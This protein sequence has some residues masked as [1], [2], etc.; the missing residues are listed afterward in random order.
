MT[1]LYV[2]DKKVTMLSKNGAEFYPG[3]INYI[4]K[5]FSHLASDASLKYIHG[6]HFSFSRISIYFSTTDN[7]YELDNAVVCA[8]LNYNGKIYV[9]FLYNGDNNRDKGFPIYE[10]CQESSS[11]G[12]SSW[13]EYSICW[14]DVDDLVF[15]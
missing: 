3:G 6:Y 14:F 11:G 15:K 2:N 10:E 8:Q 12:T 7:S 13:L 1:N 9:A 4:G 5:V